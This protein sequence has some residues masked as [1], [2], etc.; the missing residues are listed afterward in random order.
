[1]VWPFSGPKT[2]EITNIEIKKRTETSISV[3]I[4]NVNKTLNKSMTDITTEISNKMVNEFKNSAKASALAENMMRNVTIM[5][6]EGAKVN[7]KQDAA[8][9]L[10]M[11]AVINM[12]SDNEIKNDTASNIANELVKK[13][14]QDA[15]AKAE[16]MEAAR[17]DKLSKQADGLANMVNNVVGAVAGTVNNLVDGLTGRETHTEV[18]QK[19]DET[20]KTALNNEIKN[21]TIDENEVMNKIKTTVES[22]FKNLTVD[23]CFG[24]AESRNMMEQLSLIG[25]KGSEIILAQV[26]SSSA[27]AKCMVNRGIGNKALSSI[28]NDASFKAMSETAQAAKSDS[29][30][31][32]IK[33]EKIEEIKTDALADTVQQGIKTIGDVAGGLTMILPIVI[34][35]AVIGIIGF[36]FMGGGDLIA[37]MMGGGYQSGGAI[38]IHTLQRAIIL[39]AIVG[40][41]DYIAKQFK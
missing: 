5:A 2:K 9:Q 20:V 29:K 7:I 37:D 18:N 32:K 23:E 36:M 3:K 8:A 27:V 21:V 19:I 35:I 1:M 31:E 11:T 28:S 10:E 13:V 34:G 15:T 38:A 33:E 6:G 14:Q 17:L 39:V 26:A 40:G 25:G 12:I 30:L 41:I 16:L 4:E 22:E 24:N